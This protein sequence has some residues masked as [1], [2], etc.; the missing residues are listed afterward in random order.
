MV[1]FKALLLKAPVALLLLI[2]T[3]KQRCLQIENKRS[4][5]TISRRLECS[6]TSRKGMKCTLNV[7]R[8]LIMWLT[9]WSPESSDTEYSHFRKLGRL[10]PNFTLSPKNLSC[11]PVSCWT[12]VRGKR[13]AT[14]VSACLISPRPGRVAWPCV[15]SSTDT[16]QTSCKCMPHAGPNKS[17]VLLSSIF[18]DAGM[19]AKRSLRGLVQGKL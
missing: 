19:E 12:G 14:E 8:S 17:P 4:V 11:A 1:S 9:A 18:R 15:R 13:R 6:V 3:N 7:F 2:C 5:L 16:D 10:M